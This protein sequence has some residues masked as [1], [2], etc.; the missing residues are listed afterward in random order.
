MR[1][2]KFNIRKIS[3]KEVEIKAQNKKEAFEKI[4]E[5]LAMGEQVLFK[6]SNKNDDVYEIKMQKSTNEQLENDKK[7]MK[8]IVDKIIEQLEKDLQECEG[9]SE[10]TIDDIPKVY[11]EIVCEN[12]G[13]CITLDKDFMS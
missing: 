5:F 2:Y 9:N 4:I 11:D 12:C 7:K 1:K 3:E 13:N 6:N 10:E 8:K